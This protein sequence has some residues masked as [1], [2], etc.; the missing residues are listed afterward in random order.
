MKTKQHLLDTLE[1]V[2][3]PLF[4]ISRNNQVFYL[5][6]QAKDEI[7]EDKAKNIHI[8]SQDD[9]GL[10][11]CLK[12]I[13]SIFS[14]KDSSD[15]L[16]CILKTSDNRWQTSG[17]ARYLIDQDL[18][19][20]TA[21]K[22]EQ[23]SDN[24]PLE[25]DQYSP[26]IKLEL[27]KNIMEKIPSEIYFLNE[28]GYILFSNPYAN[29]ILEAKYANNKISHI[30]DINPAATS[31]WWKNITSQLEKKEHITFETKHQYSEGEEYPIMVNLFFIQYNNQTLYCYQ[32]NDIANQ[33]NIEKSL[34][35]ESK[36]NQSIAE[37][38]A[39]LAKKQR[40]ESVQL[41]VRQYA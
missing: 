40:L 21:K 36:I 2:A 24:R 32:C 20:Y 1:L 28:G 31:N 30:H 35:K 27:C 34:I 15:N 23:L 25:F 17:S 14:N 16:Q 22:L 37:L 41:L 10:V 26:I 4:L 38:S 11:D 12:Q 6:K 3:V 29:S 13:E 18:I 7:Q 9:N 19:L 8:Q 39:E 5:N 33:Y